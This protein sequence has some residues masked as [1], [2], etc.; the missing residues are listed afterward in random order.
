MNRIILG[1]GLLTVAFLTACGGSANWG[2]KK[3]P[4]EGEKKDPIVDVLALRR[5]NIALYERSTG[6]ID[7][8]DAADVYARVSE[9]ALAVHVEVGDQVQAGQLLVQLDER[10]VQIQLTSA[11]LAAE[12]SRLSL[13]KLRLDLDKTEADLKRI[14]EYYDPA[15]P[16][17]S[18]VFTKDA[19]DNALLARD[20]ARNALDA[21]EVQQKKAQSDVDKAELALSQ[22]K[23]FAPISGTV[24]ERNV[25]ANEL[26]NASTKL[27]RITDFSL[28]ELKLEVPEAS[29]RNLREPARTAV[30]GGQPQPDISTAQ[31]AFFTLTAYRNP[32]FEER[33]LG[34]VDR[35]APTVDQAR[36]MVAVTVRVV[37]PLQVDGET[38]KAILAQ[39][40]ADSRKAVLET[41]AAA[42]SGKGSYTIKP[43][44]WADARV[45][46]EVREGVL[47]APG[48]GLVGDTE[49]LWIISKPKSSDEKT[50]VA[51]R[52]DIRGRRGVT[53]E[54]VFEILMPRPSR[55]EGE[56]REGDL[57]VVRGQTLLRDGQNV[58]LNYLGQ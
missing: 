51:R 25:R 24:V 36:G 4:Q 48:A 26:V 22:C 17:S 10:N 55:G 3:A 41:A 57:V 6:R 44:M 38:H 23:I 45:A 37:P 46:S 43:G 34:F 56:L 11:R 33:F 19:Y 31:A 35:V 39:L 52:V 1:L 12:E 7:A 14:M 13:A 40:D 15:K 47:V 28:L 49:V 29:M 20:K 50:G 16:E 9:V 53:S 18:K 21:A 2:E 58:R 27:Y 30:N 32:K 42:K 54:G 8:H 5:S